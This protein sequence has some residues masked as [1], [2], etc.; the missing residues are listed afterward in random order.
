MLAFGGIAA[1]G[2]A[3]GFLRGKEREKAKDKPTT[4]ATV[5]KQVL[6]SSD[7]V[8]ADE[9]PV[10]HIKERFRDLPTFEK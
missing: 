7:E 4:V 2:L 6:L 9:Y 8:V 3:I 5:K 1:A 10:A